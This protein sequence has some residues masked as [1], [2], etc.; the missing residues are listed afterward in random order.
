MPPH[1]QQVGASIPQWTQLIDADGVLP[2]QLGH[3]MTDK[4]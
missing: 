4:G 3:A 2:W 1:F